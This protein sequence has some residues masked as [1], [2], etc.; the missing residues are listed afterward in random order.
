M[1]PLFPQRIAQLAEID[2]IERAHDVLGPDE[3]RRIRGLAAG[4]IDVLPP[5]RGA[6]EWA[7]ERARLQDVSAR[8]WVMLKSRVF[9]MR[10]RRAEW[11]R[12]RTTLA[13]DRYRVQRRDAEWLL[14]E[15]QVTRGLARI[16]ETQA[17]DPKP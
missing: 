17:R 14:S 6:S 16:V 1:T 9:M 15:W 7:S 2:R 10:Q 12:D 11:V 8:Q 4:T 13:H 5:L 3:Y